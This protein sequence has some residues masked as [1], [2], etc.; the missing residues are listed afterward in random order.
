MKKNFK[1]VSDNFL[2][3]PELKEFQKDFDNE[4]SEIST[5]EF[6]LVLESFKKN[7]SSAILV[8]KIPISLSVIRTKLL[9]FERILTK[10]LIANAPLV[11]DYIFNDVPEEEKKK[12]EKESRIKSHQ[13]AEKLFYNKLKA[14]SGGKEFWDITYQFIKDCYYSNNELD[15]AAIE[16]LRQTTVL[17]WTAIEVL[18]RDVVTLKINQHPEFLSKEQ[19]RSVPF[20]F[21]E[22]HNYNLNNR[23]GYIYSK[24]I[25]W[26][27][28]GMIQKSL[29]I[30]HVDLGA[31]L[32]S[33]SIWKLN[34]RRH[35]IVHNKGVVDS[36]YLDSTDDELPV[37]S[38]L[39]ITPK[40][41]QLHLSD[42]KLAGIEIITKLEKLIKN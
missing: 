32:K 11:S 2:L 29:E 16:L 39:L 10:E 18:I 27:N 42:V 38:E 28:Y 41:F 40:D 6:R 8:S 33:N 15:I 9:M 19:L 7:L 13:K 35:L 4:S 20:E 21:L 26:S 31:S 14:K 12:R 3:K 1:I 24:N 17:V 37:G 5:R 34:Q 36:Q 25:D 23:L 30:F 22:E